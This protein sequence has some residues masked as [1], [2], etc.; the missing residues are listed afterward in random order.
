MFHDLCW[1]F[2]GASRSGLDL[3]LQELRRAVHEPVGE[4]RVTTGQGTGAL[5]SSP[6]ESGIGPA[7]ASARWRGRRLFTD[8]AFSPEEIIKRIEAVTP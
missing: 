5:A 4:E 1:H 3:S 2:A 8:G 6:V 7:R